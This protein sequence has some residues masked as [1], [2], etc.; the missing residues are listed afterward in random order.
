MSV[1]LLAWVRGFLRSPSIFREGFSNP[2]TNLFEIQRN[3]F[4]TKVRYSLFPMISA[5]VGKLKKNPV[6]LMRVVISFVKSFLLT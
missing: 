6:G 1:A 5:P 3:H 4:N 2:V